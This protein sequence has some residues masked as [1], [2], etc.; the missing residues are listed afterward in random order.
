MHNRMHRDGLAIWLALALMAPGP[1]A[2]A[3][4]IDAQRPQDQAI[5]VELEE[6]V[7]TARRARYVYQNPQIHFDWLARLVGEF[8]VEGYVDI[9]P[10]GGAREVLTAEGTVN[11]IGFGVAPGVQCELH[12]R[13]PE[14]K[15]PGGELIPGRAPTL[16]PA[17]M[18]FGFKENSYNYKL[19][20]FVTSEYGIKHTLI[21]NK[22][23]FESGHGVYVGDDTVESRSHCS[24]VR[25]DCERMVRITAAPDLR[26]IDM[27]IEL[28]IEKHEAVRY[29]FLLRRV[30]GSKAL[31]Y[32][33][34][35]EQKNRP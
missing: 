10:R 2:T 12:V 3:D 35:P 26:T 11:C 28:T 23:V 5:D 9:N 14:M 22:G 7:V 29:V 15:G 33:R 31:V 18:L 27:L 25:A 8:A 17:M 1:A 30:P 34:E 6:I 20:G 4:S 13:W 32:G 19:G 21:D 16:D 24:A